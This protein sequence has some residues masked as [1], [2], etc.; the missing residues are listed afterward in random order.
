M[1]ILYAV[2]VIFVAMVYESSF[3]ISLA[4]ALGIAFLYPPV[5]RALD[6]APEPWQVD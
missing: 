1:L 6:I 4:I 2:G 3:W 5:T